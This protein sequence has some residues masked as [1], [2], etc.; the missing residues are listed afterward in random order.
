MWT[1]RRARAGALVGALAVVVATTLVGALAPGAPGAGAQQADGQADGQVEGLAEARQRAEEATA[2]LAALESELGELDATIAAAM[3]E[4]EAAEQAVAALAEQVRRL[5]IDRYMQVDDVLVLPGGDINARERARVLVASVA[6]HNLDAMDRYRAERQ[7]LD[8]ARATADSARAAQ[9]ERLAEMEDR[10]AVLA[11]EL[12]RLEALEA[13]RQAAEAARLEA[14]RAAAEEANR[15]VTTTAPPSTTGPG[16]S[17]P[18]TP[19][20]S[21]GG[22]PAPSG[23]WLCPVQGTNSFIDSW[24][25]PRA[26]GRWHQGVDIMS[27]RGTPV[28]LPVGGRVEFYTGGIGGLTFSLNGDDGN[29]Y[30]GAHMDA[31]AGL[32]PGW[33][34][35]GTLVGY[36]GET[37]DARGTAPHLHF[38]IHLGGYGNAV[39][40]YPT[41]RANC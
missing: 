35:A 39:N 29:Y 7:R 24:M 40:P 3:A 28:V 14:E 30:Y 5:A 15:R 19:G 23:G 12:A 18:S 17:G 13:E 32:A 4:A 41:T 36:V 20:G 33:Y 16:P 37:G 31:Y 6:G 27:P 10:R 25:A 2:A 26:G 34:P 21:G 11:A 9:S 8:D 22:T 38:E 1:F